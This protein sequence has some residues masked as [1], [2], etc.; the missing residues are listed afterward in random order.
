MKKQ[1]FAVILIGFI[2]LSYFLPERKYRLTE[3]C[4]FVTGGEYYATI[5]WDGMDSEEG[6]YEVNISD[7]EFSDILAVTCVTK[8]SPTKQLPP[9]TFDIRIFNNKKAYCVEIGNDNSIVAAEIGNLSKSRTFWVDCDGNVFL[10]LYTYYLNN[11]GAEIPEVEYI[12]E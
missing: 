5:V 2:I 4:P 11:G 12:L 1:Y 6:I 8:T 9:I 7:E 3:V 10:R